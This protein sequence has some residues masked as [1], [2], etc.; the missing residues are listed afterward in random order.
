MSKENELY[1]KFESSSLQTCLKAMRFSL[2][3][4]SKIHD[5]DT[6]G[7]QLPNAHETYLPVTLGWGED[8]EVNVNDLFITDFTELNGVYDIAYGIYKP[9]VFVVY[10]GKGFGKT[11][12]VNYLMYQWL[13]DEADDVKKIKDFDFAVFLDLEELETFEVMPLFESKLDLSYFPNYVKFEYVKDFLRYKKI[14]WLIDGLDKATEAAKDTVKKTIETFPHSQFVITSHWTQVLSVRYIIKPLNVKYVSLEL[15]LL[16]GEDWK[17]I[18]PKMMATKTYD[19]TLCNYLATLYISEKE[20][21]FKSLGK[22][23]PQ[24]LGSSVHLWL[25]TRFPSVANLPIIYR[26]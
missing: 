12:L 2:L 16:V 14:L 10:G 19:Q 17:L 8:E 4:F 26:G 15:A 24:T 3:K 1:E 20:R 23:R 11:S 7:N 18:I 21:L 25:K 13:L 9:K 6:L 22:V 5:P